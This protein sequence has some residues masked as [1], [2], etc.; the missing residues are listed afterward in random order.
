MVKK[1]RFIDEYA[2]FKKW[3][4]M[5]EYPLMTDDCKREICERIDKTV[6]AARQG[7]ITLD[8]CMRDIA[9]A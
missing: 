8:E 9:E 4:T 7:M 6:K 5:H 1:F 2:N 3:H